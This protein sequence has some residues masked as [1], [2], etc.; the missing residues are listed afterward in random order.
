M[1][2]TER[3]KPPR[4]PPRG[5]TQARVNRLRPSTVRKEHRDDKVKGLL[6][7]QQKTSV[8][9]M[10][11]TDVYHGGV[12]KTLKKSLGTTDEL[13]LK[14]ARLKAQRWIAEQRTNGRAV[15]ADDPTLADG[16]ALFQE[17][18]AKQERAPSTV[19]QYRYC[20]EGVLGDALKRRLSA[21]ALDPSWA[22]ERHEH[23]TRTRGHQVANHT[24]RALRAVYNRTRAMHPHLPPNNPVAAVVFNKERKRSDAIEYP[25]EAAEWL[26]A[27]RQIRHPVKRVLLPFALLTGARPTGEVV[28]ARWEDVD[29]DRRSLFVPKPKVRGQQY[30]IP[31]SDPMLDLLREARDAGA[32]MHA[33]NAKTFVF[34]GATKTGHIA[35]ARHPGLKSGHALRRTYESQSVAA[36]IDF[37]LVRVLTGREPKTMSERYFS[38]ESMWAEL[39]AAQER[40]S[41]HLLLH[42]QESD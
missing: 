8:T 14:D 36:Q 10:A 23:I 2:S 13:S 22:V 30:H 31:L 19:K 7:R 29:L 26:Q 16:W 24:L 38:S 27:A 40:M 6:V 41:A 39:L 9:Y 28:A 5:L 4:V 34:P 37:R 42:S 32:M 35:A 21:L 18:L 11:A 33:E 25:G 15:V 20:I 1:E 17:H 12:R 3:N